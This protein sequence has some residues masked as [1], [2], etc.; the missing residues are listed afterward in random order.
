MSLIEQ[1]STAQD[2]VDMMPPD[3]IETVRNMGY[4]FREGD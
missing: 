4:R 1:T 2:I 3:C